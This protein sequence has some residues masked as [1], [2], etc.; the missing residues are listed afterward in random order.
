[1]NCPTCGHENPDGAKFC[2]QC[3]GPLP[4]HCS[5]CRT[6]NPV[7]SK[8]C[9]ECGTPLTPARKSDPTPPHDQASSEIHVSSEQIES[10]SATDGERKTVTALFADLKGSTEFAEGA[11]PRRGARD[12]RAAVAFAPAGIHRACC[13]ATSARA[14]PKRSN[15]W[16]A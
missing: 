7:G 12:H 2:N 15:C 6:S 13:A 5:N 3:A 14:W 11:R 16:T 8:F 10:S 4:L 1:M 9:N